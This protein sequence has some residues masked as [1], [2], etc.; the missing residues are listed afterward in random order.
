MSASAVQ[1]VNP[2]ADVL[3]KKHALAMNC[4][5]AMGLQQVLCTNLGPR[6]TMKMLVGGAGQIKLTK[7]GKVLLDE[8]Q[9]QHPT[10]AV[11]ARTATAQ[12]D[13]TGDG[14][15]S[16]VLFTGELMKQAQRYLQEGVHP[17][18]IVEGFEGARE[19]TLEFLESFR[20]ERKEE[21][22]RETLIEIAR[23]SLRTKTYPEL[24]DHL[25]EICVDAV[26]KIYTPG[27]PIDLHMIEIMHMRHK[28]ALDTRFI[29]GLVLDHGA[30]HPNMRQRSENC[31]ILTLNVSLEYEKSEVNAGFFYKNAE[32]RAKLVAAERKYTD[33]KVGEIVAFCKSMRK[34]KNEKAGFIVINQKGIDPISLDLL[35]KN[36]I[37][38]IRRAKR[39]NME[40]LAKAC[41]GYAV[42]NCEDLKPECL[43]RAELVYEHTLGDAK[44]TF[45]EGCQNATSCTI[46]IRGPNDHT[47]RQIKDAIRD[48]LRAIMNAIQDKCLIPGAAAFEISAHL[49]LMK[50]KK[51]VKGRAKLGVQAFADA[52]LVIPKTLAE[53]AGLD[54]SDTIIELLEKSE[55]GKVVGLDLETGKAMQP[56]KAGVWDNY[57]VKKQFLHLSSLIATKL[58]LVD[59]VMRAGRKMGKD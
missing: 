4:A 51:T 54:K 43:G 55:G 18:V 57:R 58:L 14:T 28:S 50:Y 10:A 9:I 11:I 32:E 27:T 45:V 33:D 30:R 40:R 5:A 44:Y 12:D 59:E 37:V 13:M 16:N 15:T 23:T 17:R 49:D 47:I 1:S 42:N 19:R 25:T 7:D 21:F 2:E 22:D 26:Q 29:D 31:F 20:E 38:G 52:L 35:Q 53:N 8:M 46:L 36:G 3:G 6:G 34:G 56:G 41:G 24:A 48:G 39:R